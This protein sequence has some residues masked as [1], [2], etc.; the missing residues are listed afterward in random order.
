[1]RTFP[2]LMLGHVAG[3]ALLCMCS[4]FLGAMRLKSW[5]RS[6]SS[7]F[8]G[9]PQTAIAAADCGKKPPQVFSF[10]VEEQ[11]LLDGIPLFE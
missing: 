1:M 4:E 6:L 2:T 3:A 9:P 5:K 8:S 7:G 11:Q 10:M